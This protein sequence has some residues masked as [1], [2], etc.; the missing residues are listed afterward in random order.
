MAIHA[1]DR[2]LKHV[3]LHELQS[4]PWIE[5]KFHHATGVLMPVHSR[6]HSGRLAFLPKLFCAVLLL[7]PISE[8]SLAAQVQPRNA[9]LLVSSVNVVDVRRGALLPNQD[10][11]ITDGMIQRV[12]PTGTLGVTGVQTIDA[13]G[14]FM[15]PGLLDMHAHMRGDALPAWV[16]TDWFMPLLLAHGVTGVREMNSDCET[17]QPRPEQVCLVQMQSWRA[18]I[19]AGERLGPRLLALS[20]SRVDPPWDHEVS[21]GQA[22]QMVE[23]FKA[24]GVDLIKIY[25]RLSTES[26]QRIMAESRRLEIPAAGHI[27][28][29]ITATEASN[30]GMRSIEHAR[31][32]LFDCYPG[33]GEFRRTSQTQD[34]PTSLLQAMVREYDP[35]ECDNIFRTLAA[36]DTWYVPTHVTRRMEALADDFGFRNDPRMR[37]VPQWLAEEWLRD[38]DNTVARDSTPEGRRALMEFY[39]A[40]LKVTGEAHRAGVGVLL[41]TDAGDSFVFPGSSAHDE[42]REL[43]AAGLS[44]ADALRAATLKPAEFLGVADRYGSIEPGK[45]ADLVLLGSNPLVDIGNVRAIRAVILGGQFLDRERLNAL[46]EQA[47]A[48][49]GRPLN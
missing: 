17:Q 18:E 42:L 27:P 32:F 8:G 12:G 7:A 22:R 14:A 9:D 47:E 28:L 37:Y 39:L 16:T 43:V 2:Q 3:N 31:D 13:A 41:G 19:E 25:T 29:R 34:P 45:R 21:E 46:L 15:I 48:M 38:A 33:S 11:I 10:V 30:A 5:I 4:V 6:C 44:E 36:N 24:Q 40:G 49:A 20:T 35:A 1:A 23:Q 26:F